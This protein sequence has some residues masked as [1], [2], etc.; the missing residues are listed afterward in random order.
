VTTT[1]AK[2]APARKGPTRRERAEQAA[3][4]REQGLTGIEIGKRLGISRAYAYA[5]L[6]DPDGSA[7]RRRKASYAGTCK[8]CGA[9]TSGHNGRALA[10]EYCAACAPDAHRKW[11]P[12]KVIDALRLWA[13]VFDGAP[14]A[15]DWQP[16]MIGWD[17]ERRA[18][19]EKRFRGG[20]WP[21]V[22]TVQKV[23]GSW[24]AG[25]RAAG[26]EPARDCG[27]QPTRQNPDLIHEVARRFEAGDSVECLAG[28]YETTQKTIYAWLDRAG[29][30]RLRKD[31][32]DQRREVFV[33]L[34]NHGTP[35]QTIAEIMGIGRTTPAAWASQLRSRGYDVAYRQPDH[36]KILAEAA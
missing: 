10:P 24:T 9:P 3:I 17:D 32:I 33:A 20:P 25:L 18:R 36:P 7:D 2:S 1:T 6:E 26:F 23:F 19:A 30:D 31:D 14:S 29:V 15:P 22:T 28:V 5:L 8:G 13:R 4:L 21:T 11:T 12:E 34:W 16:S 35:T 27:N